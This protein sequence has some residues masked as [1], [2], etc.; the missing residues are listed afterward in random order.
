MVQAADPAYGYV[1]CAR[2]YVLDGGWERGRGELG[3]REM[4]EERVYVP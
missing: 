2:G 3:W 1:S 4:K